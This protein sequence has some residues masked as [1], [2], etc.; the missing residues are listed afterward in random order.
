VE[1][2]AVRGLLDLAG[3]GCVITSAFGR[4]WASVYISGY[5]TSSLINSGPYS[6]TR[7]PLYLFSLMG[8]VGLGI[9][10]GSI[11]IFALL[12]CL[13]A[14]YYPAV[15][16]QE[17][18]SL[19]RIHGPEFTSYKEQVPLFFPKFSLFSEPE[20]Y[21]L[22]TK[23]F[24]RALVDASYFVWVYGGLVLMLRLREVGILPTF[25]TIP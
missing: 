24:R 7:N 14:F 12:T 1:N 3:L 16:R 20:T 9:T 5:K 22:N 10:S 8:A 2:G 15:M 11:L 6:V 17:E 23:Q 13:F 18:A 21:L 25:F 4:I 19:E